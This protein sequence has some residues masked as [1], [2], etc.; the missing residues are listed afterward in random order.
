MRDLIKINYD[1]NN[2]KAV[3]WIVKE[4]YDKQK[5]YYE[6]MERNFFRKYW[7]GLEEEICKDYLKECFDL[8]RSL[9]Q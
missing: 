8:K 7:F 9:K 1:K 5:K 3:V 4:E 2:P 6:E